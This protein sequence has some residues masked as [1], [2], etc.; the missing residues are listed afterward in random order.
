MRL[1]FNGEAQ[2]TISEGKYFV[3]NQETMDY[4]DGVLKALEE[5]DDCLKQFR[6]RMIKESS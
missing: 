5:T 6:E 2:I 4:F 3:V 1:I